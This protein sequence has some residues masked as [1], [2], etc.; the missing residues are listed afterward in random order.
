[1]DNLEET[2]Q[3]LNKRKKT[4]DVFTTLIGIGKYL[5]KVVFLQTTRQ[6]HVET[7]NYQDK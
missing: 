4:D 7:D 1:M 5:T 2:F 6:V 3:N